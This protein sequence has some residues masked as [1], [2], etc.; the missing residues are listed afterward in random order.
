[1]QHQVIAQAAGVLEQVAQG[2]GLAVVGQLGHVLAHVVVERELAVA[3]QQQ[4][5]GGGEL[6]GGRADV[7]HGVGA[8]RHAQF[9]VGLAVALVERD[10]AVAE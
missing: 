8:D 6:L 10:R 9:Q 1:M 2:D 4:H 7:E 5:R 3:F